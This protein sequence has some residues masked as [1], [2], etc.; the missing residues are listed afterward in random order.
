[1]NFNHK[2]ISNKFIIAFIV[3]VIW[4]IFID[5]N[6]LIFLKDLDKDI[7]EL[8]EKKAFY[9]KGIKQQKQDLKDL[10]NDNKLQKYAREKL[11][12]KKENEDIYIIEKE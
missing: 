4:V 1:M 10:S 7:N 3:F 2:H 9:K 12:M 8:Q 6:S 11:L 5:S